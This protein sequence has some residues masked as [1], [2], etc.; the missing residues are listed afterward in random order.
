MWPYLVVQDVNTYMQHGNTTQEVNTHNIHVQ[1]LPLL[2]NSML[3]MA[4]PNNLNDLSILQDLES[5]INTYV[6]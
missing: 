3:L 5:M 1:Y 6:L 2:A 4:L